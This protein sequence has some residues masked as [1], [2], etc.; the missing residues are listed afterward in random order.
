MYPLLLISRRD[1]FRILQGNCNVSAIAIV[2]QRSFKL[3]LFFFLFFLLLPTTNMSANYSIRST[4]QRE[5]KI[6][7]S[8]CQSHHQIRSIRHPQFSVI[9]TQKYSLLR[10]RTTLFF[11][12]IE[13]RKTKKREQK[14]ITSNFRMTNNIRAGFL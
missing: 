7:F 12:F 13:K 8:S 1:Y 9:E 10:K 2:D 11:L 14:H 4:A 3:T 6:P 5:K